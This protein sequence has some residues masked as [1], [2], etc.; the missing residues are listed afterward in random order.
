MNGQDT[1]GNDAS[2]QY[3]TD[4]LSD[5]D[6]TVAAFVIALRASTWGAEQ[7]TH[8]RRQRL[9]VRAEAEAKVAVVA[10]AAVRAEAAAETAAEPASNAAAEAAVEAE[11]AAETLAHLEA[12]GET[13]K[14]GNKKKNVRPSTTSTSVSGGPT[15]ASPHG[16]MN[17]QAHENTLQAALD[18]MP[19][20]ASKT[21]CR[22]IITVSQTG[23]STAV[24]H[25][26]SSDGEQGQSTQAQTASFVVSRGPSFGMTSQ[27]PFPE[28]Q[29]LQL[30]LGGTGGLS[31]S[32]EDLDLSLVDVGQITPQMEAS[33]FY[34]HCLVFKVG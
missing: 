7:A 3:Q 4:E 16:F 25:R 13:A 30:E 19:P 17:E 21:I 12:E 20:E 26:A 33:A 11:A 32:A 1:D 9:Q 15:S 27:L 34:P 29:I 31:M 2:E 5:A 24:S 8:A 14:A 6:P 22:S 10:E 18:D 28:E 23:A